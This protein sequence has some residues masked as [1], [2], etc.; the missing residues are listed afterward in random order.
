MD[1]IKTLSNWVDLFAVIPVYLL[2]LYNETSTLL[3]MLNMIRYLRVFRLFKLLYDLHILGK[4][5]QASVH[6]L[7]ILLAILCVP[8]IIFS[9]FVYYAEL[10]SG[11]AKSKDDFSEIQ[12]GK[13]LI[14]FYFK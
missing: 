2:L 4:T 3:M 12:K 7:L 1:F 8:T 5:L 13:T 9:S 10:Y 6:Q 14:T 11:T